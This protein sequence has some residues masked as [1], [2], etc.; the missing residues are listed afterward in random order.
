MNSLEGDRPS[1]AGVGPAQTSVV[2]PPSLVRRSKSGESGEWV[3]EPAARAHPRRQDPAA[4][5]VARS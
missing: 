4:S 2:G 5:R 3:T 1:G